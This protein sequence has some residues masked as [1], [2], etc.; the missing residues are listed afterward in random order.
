MLIS[1]NHVSSLTTGDLDTTVVRV[2]L[3]S[4]HFCCSPSLSIIIYRNWFLS[5]ISNRWWSW[6]HI[7]LSNL[8][9]S[10]DFCRNLSISFD[11]DRCLWLLT[12]PI[13]IVRCIFTYNWRSWCNRCTSDIAI[14]YD[15]DITYCYRIF[16]YRL[17]SV[18]I[19]Q[20]LSI[21][22]DVYGYWL[23][24]LLL[25]VVNM[26]LLISIMQIVAL[27]KHVHVY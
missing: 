7:L 3:I 18:V 12:L 6:Y 22:I 25:F 2:T 15:L 27:S 20:Y 23:C 4:F 16:C 5:I 17:I 14:V 10:F 24:L 1:T 9:L 19:Y 21:S 26:Q 13:V 11:F 8:A